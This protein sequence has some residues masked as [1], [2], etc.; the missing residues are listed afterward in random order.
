[1][2]QGALLHRS[3]YDETRKNDW[4]LTPL[5]SGIRRFPLRLAR[6]CGVSGVGPWRGHP[7]AS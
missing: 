4:L 2:L 6:D 1:M 3:D 5:S 7:Q